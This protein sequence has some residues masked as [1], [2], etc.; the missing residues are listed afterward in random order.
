MEGIKSY[1]PSWIQKLE[2]QFAFDLKDE[3]DP[4]IKLR[5]AYR[6]MEEGQIPIEELQ[7]KLVL[8]KNPA[9]YPENSLQRK[10]SLENG[11]N[12]QQGDSIIYYK[13][14]KTG[15]GTTNLS[16]YSR[17]KYL[18]MFESIFEE[19]LTVMGFDFKRDIIGLT[20]LS[21]VIK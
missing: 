7:I 9:E 13:S 17:K 6:K 3:V 11:V 5:K 20:S 14:N 18:E 15:G 16:F 21:S 19:T 10:L 4:T 2:K 8:H 12:V 1:K